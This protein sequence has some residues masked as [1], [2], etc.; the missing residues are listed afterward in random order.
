MMGNEVEKCR[1]NVSS[2][3]PASFVKQSL[4]AAA[5]NQHRPFSTMTSL[6]FL[7]S[8]PTNLDKI[9]IGVL[10]GKFLYKTL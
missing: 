5:G 1:R 9:L 2:Y 6:H 4:I 8:P 3:K 10:S 7:N